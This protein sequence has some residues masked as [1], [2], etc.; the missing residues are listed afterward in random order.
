[1]RP[2]PKAAPKTEAKAEPVAAAPV[3]TVD[4]GTA[5]KGDG[6]KAADTK[7]IKVEAGK[8][9]QLINLVGELVIAS[10]GAQL[11]AHQTGSSAAI[12]TTETVNTLVEQIRDTSL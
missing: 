3:E 1:P 7:F 5:K 10:A 12:E 9:D 11:A 4:A 8:L 2:E 6:K